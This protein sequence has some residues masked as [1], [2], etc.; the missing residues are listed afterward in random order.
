[1]LRVI[2]RAE[3]GE[4]V[5]DHLAGPL[6][7][8]RGPA[9]DAP[10]CVLTDPFASRDHLRVELQ[11]DGRLR[12]ENLSH[13][14]T[15]RVGSALEVPIGGTI[16]VD[17][18]V[19]LLLGASPVEITAVAAESPHPPPPSS[20]EPPHLD[21]GKT[22][23]VPPDTSVPLAPGIE[24]VVQPAAMSN[25]PIVL[26][27]LGDAP[28][29]ETLAHWFETLV[30]V[31][32]AA[33]TSEAF[34]DA[35]ARA[36]VELVG[37]D[38]G[39]VLLREPGGWSIGASFPALPE[40]RSPFSSTVVNE[41]LRLRRTVFRN[42]GSDSLSTSLV[43]IDIVVAAPVLDGQREVIGVVYGARA[44]RPDRPPPRIAPLEALVVQVLAAAVGAGLE[45]EEQRERAMRSQLQFEQ[46]FSP[47]LARELA[48]DASLLEGRER[49]VT[50]LFSD[51][52]N[53][54][55]I[56]ERLGAQRTFAMM[57]EVMELQTAR[58]RE[59][60]GVI[61]DYVGDGLLAMWNAPADQPDHAAR[62]C[63]AAVAFL[64]DLPD[65][66]KRWLEEA[67]EPLRLGVGI[68]SGPALVGNTGSH[69][70]F[71]YGP[72]GPAVNL[73]SRMEDSTKLLG[74]SAIVTGA[75]RDRLP[76]GFGT[77]R[78]GGLRVQGFADPIEVFELY[79]GDPPPEWCDRRDGFELALAHFEGGRWSEACRLLAALLTADGDY[80][81]PSLQLLSR[82]V[83]CL[84]SNPASFD[85]SLTIQK[86]A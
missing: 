83:E 3:G 61:V 7:F 14:T 5:V 6:E 28:N 80:D 1:M 85:P 76:P 72:M 77:R 50:I 86:Q 49:E 55:R 58:I 51:V 68:H 74:V 46:F 82:S 36:V 69:I 35:T 59:T 32:Q 43:G 73:A 42:L 30:L 67:G 24:T 25:R 4:Q 22:L 84:R 48:E 31:Q 78:L 44:L 71:K 70:K 33:A 40:D 23:S 54:S 45:R 13:T 9:R 12:I 53:F 15:V 66:S 79:P 64:R 19:K 62:A 29:A 41:V 75:T 47:E 21:G 60:D 52:R 8:G 18:P 65:L 81:V 56:S 38:S 2:I 63:T 34:L 27:D 17:L 10:R 26:H 20:E 57:Q 11:E 39:L 16:A 37:L